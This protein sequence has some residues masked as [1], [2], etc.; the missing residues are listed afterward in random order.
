MEIKLMVVIKQHHSLDDFMDT[1]EAHG[2]GNVDATPDQRP[3]ADSS[4]GPI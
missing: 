4:C 2:Q 1:L 3:D